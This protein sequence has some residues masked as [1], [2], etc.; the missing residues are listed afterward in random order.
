MQRVKKV[1]LLLELARGMD[2]ALA[3][4]ISHYAQMQSQHTWSFY[5]QRQG[6][7]LQLLKL[8]NWGADGI[9]AYDPTPKDA[10]AIINSGLPSVTRGLKIPGC[11]HI[12]SNSPAIAEM[13]ADYYIE[14]GFKTF[15]FC[16]NQASE[17]STTRRDCFVQK[18]SD[19]NYDIHVYEQPKSRGWYSWEKEQHYLVKWLKELPKPIALFAANDDRARIVIEACKIAGI[20]VPEEIAIMGVD[21]DEHV[22]EL[23]SPP[24]SS[25]ALNTERIGMTAAKMLDV[26]MTTGDECDEDI[27]LQP[28][29]VI[30][31]Q[32]TNIQAIE[33]NEIAKAISYINANAHKLIQVDDVVSVTVLGRR[34]L[35]KR[36]RKYLRRSIFNEINSIQ[37]QHMATMLIDTNMSITDIAQV[38]GYP[39]AKHISR[40][41]RKIKKMTPLQYRKKNSNK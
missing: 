18:L 31:R 38:M 3:R 7:Q 25:I 19:N 36:F 23:S 11:P 26:M 2:R 24:L 37:V 9:I 27:V 40:S 20:H 30:T 1:V 8:K 10:E 35:E 5:S 29:H 17:W 21:N 15:A 4:G 28:T 41:F 12:V 13:A 16:G 34:A 33:D 14:R 22:C 39:S 32:S 6:R